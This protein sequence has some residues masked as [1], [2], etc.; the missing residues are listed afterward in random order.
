ME[1]SFKKI[2]VGTRYGQCVHEEDALRAQRKVGER[3]EL[4]RLVDFVDV[5][6]NEASVPEVVVFES[7]KSL[8]L[9]STNDHV[10]NVMHR[11]K[12]Q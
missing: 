3:D 6:L 4:Q 10:E 2:R 11:K 9:Y 5:D 1:A 12:L 8:I 7:A